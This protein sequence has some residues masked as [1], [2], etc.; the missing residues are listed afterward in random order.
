M[1]PTGSEILYHAKIFKIKTPP[2]VHFPHGSVFMHIV[3]KRMVL[4]FINPPPFY[5]V[6]D[7]AVSADGNML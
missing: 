2:A 5:N 6:Q 4:V 7:L 3:D 1:L